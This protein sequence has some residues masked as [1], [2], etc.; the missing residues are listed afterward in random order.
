MADK[1]TV[2]QQLVVV[3]CSD[4]IRNK[5]PVHATVTK[6]GR[7]YF[8]LNDPHYGRFAIDT[9]I[10][11]GGEYNARYKLYLSIEDYNAEQLH[12]K[13]LEEVKGT[14]NV[15]LLRTLSANQLSRILTILQEK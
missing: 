2:G 11:D 13:L 14:L 15:M 10:H 8:E 9:M 5:T 1:I 6:V 3:P 7:K 4:W 12:S